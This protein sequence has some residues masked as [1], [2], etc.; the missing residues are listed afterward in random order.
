MSEN[1]SPSLSVLH[2][3]F[4]L[5]VPARLVLAHSSEAARKIASVKGLIWKIWLVE[6]EQREV[7]GVYLFE[8]REDAMDYL[9]HPVVH[10]LCTNPGVI[11]TDS[12]I[13]DVEGSLS[14]LTRGPLPGIRAE[15]HEH[16]MAGGR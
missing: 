2:L 14:S 5:R 3:R 7:G 13:W 16:V 11:A 12:Q 8:R 4:K 1:S 10:A 6:H 9:N 15:E